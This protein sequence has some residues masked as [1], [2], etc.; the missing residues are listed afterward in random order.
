MGSLPRFGQKTPGDGDVVAVQVVGASITTFAA[1]ANPPP[2]GP[3]QTDSQNEYPGLWGCSPAPSAQTLPKK[4][5]NLIRSPRAPTPGSGALPRAKG[6]GRTVPRKEVLQKGKRGPGSPGDSV[7]RRR[8]RRPEPEPWQPSA[9]LGPVPADRLPLRSGGGKEAP[10]QRRGRRPHSPWRSCSA[11]HPAGPS[12]AVRAATDPAAAPL[13]Q[14]LCPSPS[15][16]QVF[17]AAAAARSPKQHSRRASAPRRGPARTSPRGP[18]PPRPRETSPGGKGAERK[19]SSSSARAPQ[20][21][22]I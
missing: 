15:P 4:A 2:P 6:R 12:A 3:S 18:A 1:A 9:G 20:V 16:L 7:P 14:R 11:P 19:R 5:W 22:T 13:R 8:P 10:E 17:F 21:A